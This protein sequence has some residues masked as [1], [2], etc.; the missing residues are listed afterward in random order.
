MPIYS[1][2]N[3]TFKRVIVLE[4]QAEIL[5]KVKKEIIESG[6][7]VIEQEK[8]GGIGGDI[9]DIDI[10]EDGSLRTYIEGKKEPIRSYADAMTVAITTAYKRPIARFIQNFENMSWIGRIISAIMI[11]KNKDIFLDYSNRL[12]N[13]LPLLLKDEHWSQP[14]KEIRRVLKG[15]FSPTAVDA[16]SL[17]IDYDSA[18]KNRTQDI[19]PELDQSKLTGTISSIKEIRRVF[20]I[21]IERDY[22]MMKIKW[23]KLKKIVTLAMLIPKVRKKVVSILKKLDL[24]EIKFSK[25]DLYWVRQFPSYEYLGIPKAEREKQN[26][27]IYGGTY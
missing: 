19:L 20:D 21:I 25:E 4:K 13:C 22:D 7:K 2:F 11:L 6:E 16:V 14:V 9:I 17:I 24:N 10:A 5:K 1:E 27:K 15:E 26:I 8:K 12:F 18:Y 3:E 23:T